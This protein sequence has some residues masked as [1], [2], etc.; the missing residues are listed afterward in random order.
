[1][2][3]V[4]PVV[5]TIA[6][7]ISAPG[8]GPGAGKDTAAVRLRVTRD[9]GAVAVTE[10]AVTKVP[11]SETAMR[12]LARE[13]QLKTRYGGGF[14]QCVKDLCGG[15]RGGRNYDWFY[16]VN[17][18][19]APKGAAATRVRANDSIWWDLRD[20]SVAERVPAVVGQ[21]PEPFR[22][23]PGV[24]GRLP[25]RIECADVKD[26]ACGAVRQALGREDVG[27]GVAP[28]RATAAGESLR[29]IVGTWE[30]IGAER[31]LV[32]L[33][34]GP[35]A[36]GIYARPQDR[37]RAIALLDPAGRT[38]RTLGPGG[39]LV[40]AT[41]VGED[42]PVWVVTGTD[43]AGVLAAARALEPQVLR[44]RYAVAVDS[45]G[46]VGLPLEAAR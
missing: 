43:A 24:P 38:V 12:L 6:I 44:R 34:D 9:F 19:E 5:G 4:M 1:M 11:A 42:P 14:V 8:C 45:G 13:A 26:A 40:A 20:W 29:I 30:Q 2:R 18:V 17:G 10:T 23:G 16:F 22:H 37:G 36:S 7:L 3:I 32:V 28:L 15:R 33:E 25:T 41:R 39:G 27:D 21:F 46:P 35:A 31:A